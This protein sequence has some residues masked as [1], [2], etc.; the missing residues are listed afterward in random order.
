MKRM[1]LYLARSNS[2]SRKTAPGGRASSGRRASSSAACRAAASA[3]TAPRTSTPTSIPA[4]GSPAAI[5]RYSA[6]PDRNGRICSVGGDG[7]RYFATLSEIPFMTDLSVV[8]SAGVMTVGVPT[9]SITIYRPL[10]NKTVS[11]RS[12]VPPLPS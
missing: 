3:S 4:P 8:S 2:P 11:L 7:R 10:T 9:V 5:L 6:A 12:T 1:I